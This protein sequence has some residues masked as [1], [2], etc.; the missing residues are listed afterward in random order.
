MRLLALGLLV[1]AGVVFGQPG[2]SQAFE[3]ASI[4]IS[5]DP[6]GHSGGH[7]HT[8]S[9]RYVNRTLKECITAAYGVQDF[10]V[11]GGPAW[12]DSDRYNI[13]AKAAGPAEDDQ[14]ALMMQTLLADRFQLAFHR[15]PRMIQGYALVTGKGGIKIKPNETDGNSTTHTTRASMEAVNMSMAHLAAVVSGR[16]GVPIADATGIA[17]VFNITMEWNPEEERSK[18][19]AA[20]SR[21]EAPQNVAVKPSLPEVLQEQ[22][23]LKLEPRKVSVQVIIIDRAEKPSEN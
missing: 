2:N 10:E 11:S 17:G 23:G 4:K 9:L 19:S 7:S 20:N 16:L 8:G 21:P 5:T 12:L 3:V 6:P 13:D 18:A 15:E 14:L 22:L 1:S